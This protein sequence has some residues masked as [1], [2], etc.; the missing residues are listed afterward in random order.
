[1]RDVMDQK[2]GFITF[3]FGKVQFSYNSLLFAENYPKW[4]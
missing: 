1:M 2:I 4:A 3:N